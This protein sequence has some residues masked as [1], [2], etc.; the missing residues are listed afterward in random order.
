MFLLNELIPIDSDLFNDLVN[1]NHSSTIYGSDYAGK[2]T[3]LQKLLLVLFHQ[4]CLLVANF[5]SLW[6]CDHVVGSHCWINFKKITPKWPNFQ[7]IV[8]QSH[9]SHTA[10]IARKK[11][12]WDLSEKNLSWTS[13][14]WTQPLFKS[15]ISIQVKSQVF[16]D[17]RKYVF[18][19]MRILILITSFFMWWG[20]I[21]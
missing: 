15:L 18:I 3:S 17:W 6:S 8:N 20:S 12:K 13:A 14:V 9:W 4:L 16:N 21:S 7:G 2:Q 1:G 19:M 11:Q 5:V 10:Q